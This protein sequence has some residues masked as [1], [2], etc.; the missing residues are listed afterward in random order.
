M[1]AGLPTCDVAGCVETAAD[2]RTCADCGL[3]IAKCCAHGGDSANVAGA[4]KSVSRGMHV[5]RVF[6][7]GT[8][9]HIPGLER[10]VDPF[11]DAMNSERPKTRGDCEPCAVCQAFANGD[12]VL[13]NG[14]LELP[15][16][17][18]VD[19]HANHCRPCPWVSCRHH[20]LIEIAYAKPEIGEN[21]KKRDA[22]PTSI[23]LNKAQPGHMGRH[24]ASRIGRRPGIRGSETN[25]E[26]AAWADNAVD[27]LAEMPKTC[28]LDVAD[29]NQDGTKLAEIGEMLG[30]TNEALRQ[31]GFSALDDLNG[32]PVKL[33]GMTAKLLRAGLS[34]YKDHAPSDR[35][36]AL[37]SAIRER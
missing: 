13:A 23:R 34:E 14:D 5:H 18:H 28:S 30:V 8:Q 25:V 26:F 36:S 27:H 20:A 17:H 4:R 33:A 21:G 10:P 31:E 37:A 19:H 1:I 2:S 15:C 6:E 24:S 9:T 29:A 35:M 32:A 22:R 12:A 7:H 11:I 16:G 3:V